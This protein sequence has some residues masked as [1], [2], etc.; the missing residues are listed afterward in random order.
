MAKGRKTGGG[1][2]RG[3]PN[4]ITAALTDAID[5]AFTQVG[6][7]TYLVKVATDD[8]KTFCAL[9]G[10]RLPKDLNVALSVS[11]VD[12]IKALRAQVRE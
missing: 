7:A 8:P 6:G 12:A 1:S 9:L 5:E 4:K 10:K 11:L 2:R 3:V